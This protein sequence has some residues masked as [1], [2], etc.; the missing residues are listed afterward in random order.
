MVQ[1]QDVMTEVWAYQ[2]VSVFRGT[3]GDALQYNQYNNK[4][5]KKK[6]GEIIRV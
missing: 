1:A 6:K 4:S 2:I 3:K 5:G